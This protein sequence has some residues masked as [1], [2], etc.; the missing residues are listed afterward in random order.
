MNYQDLE[1]NHPERV[2]LYNVKIQR[3]NMDELVTTA[4]W[5]GLFFSLSDYELKDSD[6]IFA[7]QNINVQ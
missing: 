4:S 5:D 3:E 6:Y 1:D 7:W 2:G